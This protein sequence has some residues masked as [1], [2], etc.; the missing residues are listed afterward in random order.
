MAD[1]PRKAK[2]LG[3][4]CAN[5]D[6]T[7]NGLKLMAWLSEAVNP[8]HGFSEEEVQKIW[9]EVKAKKVSTVEY[10]FSRCPQELRGEMICSMAKV[11]GFI[12]GLEGDSNITM[13]T[14]TDDVEMGDKWFSV[15]QA[16]H[17]AVLWHLVCVSGSKSRT[18]H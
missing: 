1:D 6:G 13:Y 18:L 12:I 14:N 15:I 16:H 5:P 3:E 10:E 2:T 11:D 8:G 9:E 4:A 7:Y 17:H